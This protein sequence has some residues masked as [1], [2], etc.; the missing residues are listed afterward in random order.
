MDSVDRRREGFRTTFGRTRLRPDW[1]HA[2]PLSRDRSLKHELAD[3]LW[4]VLVL[5]QLYDVDPEKELLAMIGDASAK[6][7]RKSAAEADESP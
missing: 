6:L 1:M 5:A 4:S 7:R 2:L 3:C